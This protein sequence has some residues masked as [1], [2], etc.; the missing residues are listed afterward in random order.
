MGAVIVSGCRG[1]GVRNVAWLWTMPVLRAQP[2]KW[3]RRSSQ[4]RNGPPF[5]L[6]LAPCK[7][8]AYNCALTK[9]GRCKPVPLCAVKGLC[10]SLKRA[11]VRLIMRQD[12][13]SS[14]RILRRIPGPGPGPLRFGPAAQW[15][16][17][18]CTAQPPS[19]AVPTLRHG[20]ATRGS[21]RAI[22][23]APAL[24]S[25]SARPL[26]PAAPPCLGGAGRTPAQPCGGGASLSGKGLADLIGG[27]SRCGG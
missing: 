24:A 27:D 15:R 13:A 16:A 9:G 25:S 10:P 12:M 20:S 7:R 8:R 1:V 21:G 3:R 6:A 18:G 26:A 5:R 14:E 11:R 4:H 23:S 17:G 19:A 2:P 22:S